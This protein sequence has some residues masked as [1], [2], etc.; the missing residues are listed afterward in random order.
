M[1]IGWILIGSVGLAVTLMLS[2]FLGVFE[3]RVDYNTQIKP[4]LNKNCIV[5]HGGVKKAANFSLLFKHE[6]LAPAK[7]G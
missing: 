7:S 3:K 4:L 6:A 2:S 5:C 1:K